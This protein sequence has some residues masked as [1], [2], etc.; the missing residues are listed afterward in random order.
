MMRAFRDAGPLVQLTPMSKTGEEDE[1]EGYRFLFA[2][3]IIAII[4]VAG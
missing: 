1:Q 3:S 4:I 2:G